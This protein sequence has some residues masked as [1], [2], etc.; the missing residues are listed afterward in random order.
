MCITCYLSSDSVNY[1]L[2]STARVNLPIHISV[3]PGMSYI[4]R[5]NWWGRSAVST[6]RVVRQWC[7]FYTW[8]SYRLVVGF[9]ENVV[10]PYLWRETEEDWRKCK[11]WLAGWLTCHFSE[12]K[13][14]ISN[15]ILIYQQ[16]QT[17]FDR[18]V[19]VPNLFGN[20][21]SWLPLKLCCNFSH[22][23]LQ[24]QVCTYV[25]AIYWRYLRFFC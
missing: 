9:M 5:G 15:F 4:Y 18:G 1:N 25:F 12:T 10:I 2:I 13:F 7:L 24:L 14:C 3:L 8:N 19:Q 23:K 6:C 22:F 17:K 21:A 16:Q 20:V 11:D